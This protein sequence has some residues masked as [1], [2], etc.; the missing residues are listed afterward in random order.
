MHRIPPSDIPSV[1]LAFVVLVGMSGC[2]DTAGSSPWS[3]GDKSSEGDGA[4][5]CVQMSAEGGG[6]VET[7]SCSDPGGASV[8]TRE[9]CGT[10]VYGSDE[11][12]ERTP[13]EHPNLELMALDEV[14]AFV[15]PQCLYERIVR[16]VELLRKQVGGDRTSTGE[17]FYQYS[18]SSSGMH[19]E[20]RFEE[21]TMRSV[22]SGDYEAWDCL[23]EYYGKTN[24]QVVGDS[25]VLTL[26]GTYDVERVAKGYAN[27]PGLFEEYGRPVGPKGQTGESHSHI[28]MKIDG[29]TYHYV[30]VRSFGDCIAGC[31]DD[32]GK[33]FTTTPSG[34]V[35][36]H[37]EYNSKT[38]KGPAPEWTEICESSTIF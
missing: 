4:G 3:F 37:G 36:K 2:S 17:P 31:T 11:Q 18:G 24:H 5:G 30:L 33:Y 10:T 8:V 21:E 35:C 15:A 20:I 7:I 22:E 13:R 34:R 6:E 28:C 16:D 14:G 19:L 29:G 1:A 23:N 25:V 27:L 32:D 38:D 12:L 9:K 26:E